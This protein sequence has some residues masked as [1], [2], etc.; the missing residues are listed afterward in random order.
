MPLSH[1]TFHQSNSSEQQAVSTTDHGCFR[2][3]LRRPRDGIRSVG[4]AE[5]AR[6]EESEDHRVRR[7]HEEEGQRDQIQVSQSIFI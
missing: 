2:L 6:A 3:A 5:D 1:Q 4:N 7:R